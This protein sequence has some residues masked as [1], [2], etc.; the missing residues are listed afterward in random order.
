MTIHV[1]SVSL[2]FITLDSYYWVI[3]KG[4]AKTSTFMII[5]NE[6]MI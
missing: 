1:G 5:D 2:G 4:I 6:S 3:S